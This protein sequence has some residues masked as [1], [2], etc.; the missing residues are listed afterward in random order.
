ME[1]FNCKE[2]RL[3]KQKELICANST[4]LRLRAGSS[5]RYHQIRERSR[6]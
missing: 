1:N 4:A 5:E 6:S 3:N 2:P